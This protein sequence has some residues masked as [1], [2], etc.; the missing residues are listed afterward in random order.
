MSAVR[1]IA[2][3]R[4]LAFWAVSSVIAFALAFVLG[5]VWQGQRAPHAAAVAYAD[6]LP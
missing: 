4:R 6:N 2:A 1:L 3:H 5:S